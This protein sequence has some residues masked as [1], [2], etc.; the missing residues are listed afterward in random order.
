MNLKLVLFV[1]MFALFA[2]ACKKETPPPPPAPA[3]E[4]A[5]VPET[6]K[7]VYA[8]AEPQYGG[9]RQKMGDFMVELATGTDGQMAAFIQKYEGDTP[10]FEDVQVEMQLTANVDA[11]AKA[12]EGEK[13]EAEEK[14]PEPQDVIFFVKD[15]KL[16]GTVA[17]LT[18]GSY[19]VA[20]K[21]Y[22]LKSDQVAEQI[23]KGVEIEPLET[24]LEPKHGGTVKIVDKA[25]MEVAHDGKMVKIWF[26]DLEDNNIKPEQAALTDL[27]ISVQ[28]GV[29]ENVAL[30]AKD[31]HFVTEVSA[32]IVPEQFK[33]L[34]A[35]LKIGEQAYPKLRVANLVATAKVTADVVKKAPPMTK[36]EAKKQEEPKKMK[37]TIGT[38]TVG[39]LPPGKILKPQASVSATATVSGKSKNAKVSAA[40]KAE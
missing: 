30:E 29:K 35:N 2:V 16:Q 31:D 37:G 39:K 1:A 11:E 5:Q 4:V 40:K 15:G 17:G 23:F 19:D 9:V 12:A 24:S 20:V 33:I 21:I 22:D 14:T 27:V 34:M 28:D 3:A 25:K 26:R 10:A 7:I 36:G 13:E 38:M 32:D 6:P 18:K 8:S